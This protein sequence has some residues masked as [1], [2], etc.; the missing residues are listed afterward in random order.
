[1]P[2]A[3][4][5]ASSSVSNDQMPELMIQMI[6]CIN[7][8]KQSFCWRYPHYEVIDKCLPATLRPAD[9]AAEELLKQ[10]Y[11]DLMPRSDDDLLVKAHPLS[12]VKQ[13]IVKFYSNNTSERYINIYFY[14]NWQ[15]FLRSFVTTE[16][17][18][19]TVAEY[20]GTYCLTFGFYYSC[21]SVIS[22][23]YG[24]IS[25]YISCISVHHWFGH[26]KEQKDYR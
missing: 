20:I 10:K 21:Q 8:G 14:K 3:L 12:Q 18:L 2:L 11:S 6:D 22:A 25:N 7:D 1:M 4:L 13:K 16:P 5:Q 24:T 9:K 26:G 15:N 19:S 17:R 23:A